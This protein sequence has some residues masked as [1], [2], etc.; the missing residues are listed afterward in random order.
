MQ[1]QPAAHRAMTVVLPARPAAHRA[2]TVVWLSISET[3]L[4]LAGISSDLKQH[5]HLK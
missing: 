4:C 1:A 3:R 5:L 2:G